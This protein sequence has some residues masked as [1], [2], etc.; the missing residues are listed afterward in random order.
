[1]SSL[2]LLQLRIQ[3]AILVQG[4][5]SDFVSSKSGM[6]SI[7]ITRSEKLLPLKANTKCPSPCLF[8][9]QSKSYLNLSLSRRKVEPIYSREHQTS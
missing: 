7:L 5:P 1:M 6:I 3:S 2:R 8:E 9:D 4:S